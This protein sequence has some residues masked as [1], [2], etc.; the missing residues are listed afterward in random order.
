MARDAWAVSPYKHVIVGGRKRSWITF[1]E[2]EKAIE[3]IKERR[4]KHALL[5]KKK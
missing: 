3:F 5:Y 2:K 1:S 4:L